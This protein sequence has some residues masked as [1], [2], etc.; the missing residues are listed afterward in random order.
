MG[1]SISSVVAPPVAF[2]A[3]WTSA[4]VE[5]AIDGRG[6]RYQDLAHTP[7]EQAVIC[8]LGP[9]MPRAMCWIVGVIGLHHGVGTVNERC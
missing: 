5:L 6:V 4:V 1:L 8:E 7:V 3:D 2:P 9:I